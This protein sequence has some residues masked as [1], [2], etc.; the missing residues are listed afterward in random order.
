ME[1]CKGTCKGTCRTKGQLREFFFPSH[2]LFSRSLACPERIHVSPARWVIS[3]FV[4]ASNC[5][6]LSALVSDMPPLHDCRTFFAFAIS[7]RI[8]SE[9]KSRFQ[10]SNSDLTLRQCSGITI[11]ITIIVRSAR[12]I[13]P[14]IYRFIPAR[15]NV[16]SD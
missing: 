13:A 12:Y 8:P 10:L 3:A 6:I 2:A 14:L 9:R 7:L 15:R 11:A 5:R 16:R 4:F 1:T